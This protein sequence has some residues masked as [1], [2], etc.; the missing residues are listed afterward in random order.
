MDKYEFHFPQNLKSKP[1]ILVWEVRDLS[2]I[3]VGTMISFYF[4]LSR[5]FVLPSVFTIIYAIMTTRVNEYTILSGLSSAL[6]YF[7]FECQEY[8][9]EPEGRNVPKPKAR[10]QADKEKPKQ[11]KK[12]SNVD[13]AL[14]RK[15]R[16]S[17]IRI[18]FAA[19]AVV[20]TIAASIWY[21]RQE[22]KK[23]AANQ[24]YSEISITFADTSTIEY[25]TEPV[26]AKSLIASSQGTVTADPEVISPSDPGTVTVTYT[27]SGTTEYGDV[28]EKKYQKEFEIT[29]TQ[30]PVIET[31]SETVILNAGQKY[32][33]YSNIK[34]V[35]DTVDGDLPLSDTLEYGTYMVTGSA[36]L[37]KA[38]V[39]PIT[40]DACDKNGKNTT[41][42]YFIEVRE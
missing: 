13:L 28:V 11:K 16:E 30:P 20:L 24:L 31:G 42:I 22:K 41:M 12:K 9:W 26:D 10:P 1:T 35:Y 18:G 6:N 34:A 33:I 27:V 40:V 3:V 2:V 37:S 21:F 36:D 25:G 39:Y 38:G 14:A 17:A 23:I 32:D 29:D 15:K 19:S 7:L 4:L 8:D 5:R